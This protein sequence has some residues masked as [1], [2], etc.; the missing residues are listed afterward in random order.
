MT[1]EEINKNFKIYNNA[2]ILL[3]KRKYEITTPIYDLETFSKK[4]RSSLLITGTKEINDNIVIFFYDPIGEEKFG[5][6]SVRFYYTK[7]AEMNSAKEKTDTKEPWSLTKAIIVCKE[8][9]TPFANNKIIEYSKL[10]SNPIDMEIFLDNFLMFDITTHSLQ[11]KFEKLSED[12]KQKLLDT[13]KIKE[14]NLAKI[15]TTDPIVK[16]YGFKKGNVIKITCLSETAG[17]YTK[18]RVVKQSE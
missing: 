5:V 3:K 13:Y 15:L 2:I 9:I 12:E 4:N 7:I 18:Y 1:E 10:E 11:P 14:N 6:K 8:E 16:Y 17:T